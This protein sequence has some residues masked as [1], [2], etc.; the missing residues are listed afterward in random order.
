MAESGTGCLVLDLPYKEIE[1]F[2]ND[3]LENIANSDRY[4]SKDVLTCKQI[5]LERRIE[6][7]ESDAYWH[8]ENAH[9]RV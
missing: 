8:E 1:E 4:G 5:L 9:R 3:Q 2:T 6:K 7:L